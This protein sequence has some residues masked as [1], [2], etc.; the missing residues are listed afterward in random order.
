ME[1]FFLHQLHAPRKTIYQCCTFILS[2]FS[3]SSRGEGARAR[4]SEKRASI[5]F[6]FCNR[7]RQNIFSLT[8]GFVFV[9][10][11]QIFLC[12]DYSVSRNIIF[13]LIKNIFFS[14]SRLR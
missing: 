2:A 1:V 8:F 13:T 14:L 5:F 6:V 11:K 7:L 3:C 12:V 9:S 4:G 10:E